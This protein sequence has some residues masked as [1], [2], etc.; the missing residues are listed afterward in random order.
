MK[1]TKSKARR[2]LRVGG[3]YLLSLPPEFVVKNN[4]KPGDKLGVVYD[5]QVIIASPNP[6]KEQN[7]E[8][9]ISEAK[10]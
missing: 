3:S 4:I 8:R 1:M 9:S 6:P 5:T 10:S 2:V 7:E